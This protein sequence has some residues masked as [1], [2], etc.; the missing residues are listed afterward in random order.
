MKVKN[1]IIRFRLFIR[2]FSTASLA[3]KGVFI[4]SGSEGLQN[5]QGEL[6]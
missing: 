3:M 4:G 5:P 6:P 2:R 1:F